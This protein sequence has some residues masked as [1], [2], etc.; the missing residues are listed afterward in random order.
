MTHAPDHAGPNTFAAALN[1]AI[2]VR[3]LS[4]E[5]VQAK[6]AA[7]GISVSVMTLSFW[8]RGRSRPER[9]QSLRAVTALEELL[10]L[11]GGSLTA[12][13][14]P[15]RHRGKGETQP[16]VGFDQLYDE[17][18]SLRHTLDELGV[19][20][21]PEVLN[22]DLTWLSMHDRYEL[23][24]HGAEAK[25]WVHHVG[26]AIGPVDVC[27]V[28]FQADDPISPAGTLRPLRGCRRGRV[29]ADPE[30]GLMV[31]ELLFDRMLNPGEIVVFEYEMRF[32]PGG[33]PEHRFGRIFGVPA[34]LYVAE[35]VFDPEAVPVNIHE[36]SQAS[37]DAEIQVL[38][39]VPLGESLTATM[40]VQDVR[41]GL[42]AMEWEWAGHQ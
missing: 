15:P 23:D 39:D 32:E 25:L 9:A 7:E 26:R 19:A 22:P 24:R 6:L 42:H 11:P 27:R 17:H 12:L 41:Q 40:A 35:V 29:R 30:S 37:V 4:L 18:I 31:T 21:D 1:R 3:G 8:R 14:G 20:T 10:G 16:W 28:T 33:Q 13:L 38:R 5:R 36:Y 2:E 34:G